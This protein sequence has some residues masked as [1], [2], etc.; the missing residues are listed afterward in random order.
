VTYYIPTLK[1]YNDDEDIYRLIKLGEQYLDWGQFVPW[2][3]LKGLPYWI[4]GL[5]ESFNLFSLFSL[6]LFWSVSLLIVIFLILNFF[7]LSLKS[8]RGLIFCL[9]FLFSPGIIFLGITGRFEVANIFFLYFSL[10]ALGKNRKWLY[11]LFCAL[12]ARPTL[13]IS[14]ILMR[15]S[16]VGGVKFRKIISNTVIVYFSAVLLMIF[17]LYVADI[18]FNYLDSPQYLFKDY[19]DWFRNY[20]NIE[21]RSDL[22]K[23][24]IKPLFSPFIESVG[25]LIVDFDVHSLNGYQGIFRIIL[26]SWICWKSFFRG[27][28]MSLSFL[29]I[30]LMMAVPLILSIGFYQARYL[31]VFDA[32]L[33]IPIIFKKD[34]VNFSVNGQ[35]IQ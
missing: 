18:S 30:Y 6:Y 33:Y 8:K 15:L 10:I 25:Y 34:A 27:D 31:I 7:N 11:L 29:N 22:W 2:W 9:V 3:A 5:D 13:L 4:S 1:Y 20:F 17:T 23:G 35:R 26:F 14:I 21:T 28:C 32:L 24:F 16:F 19:D 12:L